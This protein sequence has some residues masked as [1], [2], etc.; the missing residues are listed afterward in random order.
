VDLFDAP[1]TCKK[2][3]PRIVSGVVL[4]AMEEQQTTVVS[5][6]EV[7]AALESYCWRLAVALFGRTDRRPP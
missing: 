5:D 7:T 1:E 3:W 4:D 2:V 6:A